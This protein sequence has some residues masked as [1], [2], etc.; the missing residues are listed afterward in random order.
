M[1]EKVDK[2]TDLTMIFRPMLSFRKTRKSDE[3]FLK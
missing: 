3:V 2:P 1:S